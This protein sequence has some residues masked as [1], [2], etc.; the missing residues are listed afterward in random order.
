[1][2]GVM[3]VFPLAIGGC[4]GGTIG[5]YMYQIV[6]HNDLNAAFDHSVFACAGILGLAVGLHMLG[7]RRITKAKE[8]SK[9]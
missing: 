5:T 9:T 3:S 8:E 2:G 7:F 1:M 4:I 6:V